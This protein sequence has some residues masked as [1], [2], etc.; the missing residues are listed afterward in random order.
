M[1]RI[2][3]LF[4][5]VC[6]VFSLQAQNAT[7]SGKVFLQGA[8]DASSSL[9]RTYLVQHAAFPLEQPYNRDP[10]NYPGLEAIA[11]MDDSLV[12]WI[13]IELRSGEDFSYQ[14]YQKAVLLKKDGTILDTNMS[15]VLSFPGIK[16]APYYVILRHRNHMPVMTAQPVNLPNLV[17]IDFTD[18]TQT[19]V[20]GGNNIGLIQLSAG[21]FG[22]IAGDLNQDQV[23][24]FS[25][26]GNDR[27]KVI[28]TLVA[29]TGSQAITSTITGYHDE[30]INL[31]T[32][33]KYSGPNNDP[34]RIIQNI[35][36]LTGST[37]INTVHRTHVPGEF[38][39]G[40]DLVDLRDGKTYPT[41]KIGRQC[42]MAKN[43]DHGQWIVDTLGQ[44][45]NQ[46]V[47]KFCYDN[48]PQ[49]C[50]LYGGLY[51]WD[52][53]MAYQLDQ[54]DQGICPVGW[55]LPTDQEWYELESSL[56]PMMPMPDSLG[57]RGTVAGL[58]FISSGFQSLMGGTYDTNATFS[59]LNS[60]ARY[61]TS[62]RNP[63]GQ[64]MYRALQQGN[65]GVLRN[66]TTQPAAM[67]VRCVR[68]LAVKTN[69][70]I[71][72]IDTNTTKLVSDSAMLAQGIYQYNYTAKDSLI[73]N[74]DN[75]IIDTTGEGY[76]R[77]VDSVV[78]LGSAYIMYTRQG[79]L[80]DLFIQGDLSF[81][82]TFQDSTKSS[83]YRRTRIDYLEKGIS[84][85]QSKEAMGFDF[86]GTVLFQDGP[87]TIT[88]TS[89]HL[90]FDPEFEFDLEIKEG[91]VRRL[92]FYTEDALLEDALA[93]NFNAS[94]SYNFPEFEKTLATYRHFFLYGV[95]LV[96]VEMELVATNK[97]NISGNLDVDFGYTNS[98]YLD[99]G[100]IY[101]NGKW[102]HLYD[103]SNQ[104]T[105]HPLE[106]SAQVN[107]SQRAALVPKV[108]VKLYGIV[109]PYFNA[110]AWETLG[111]N[112]ILPAGD[113][114][115][116]LSVGL[117]AYL[118]AEA[119]VFGYEL[120]SYS[121]QLFGKE[122]SIWNAPYN[123]AKVSGD[124]QTATAGQQLPLPIKVR[125]KDNTNH[126]WL[127]VMVHFETNDGSVSNA[128]VMTDADGY[129][130]TLW[131]LG[132]NTGSQS[133][134]ARVVKADGSHILGSPLQFAATATPG[135]ST[136]TCGATLTD[137][138][139]GQ[140][141]PTVQIGTQCWMAKNL[142]I[143]VYKASVNTGST[144]SDVSNNGI[145]EKYC[146]NNDQA[147]C[148]IY[149]GLYDWNEMMNYTTTPG[150]QG[151]CP[152]GWHIPTDAEW[153]TL[154]T[155]LDATVN[156]NTWDWSGTNAGGKM[157]E[158]G[159]THW[160]SPNTGATNS[161]GFTA[162]GAGH[163]LING[164]FLGLRYDAY[165]WSSS[166]Y[167]ST[168]GI[169]RYLYYYYANVFRSSYLKT[170]GFSVRCL[171]N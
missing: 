93:I 53:M 170:D 23:L 132:N 28:T 151:I 147:N 133:L 7:F 33:V 62:T 106:W 21:L 25:G 157:K 113:W 86:D 115:A 166:E 55:H 97:G 49:N 114:D 70:L 48:N 6:I 134:T 11:S 96:V 5:F 50:Q 74:T 83:P 105:I 34:S 104:L 99:L 125:V 142:N 159:T 116:D 67:Y 71:I 124:N 145:I 126:S 76:L 108:S 92:A 29:K 121:K 24:K 136:F 87:V 59:G 10:W 140:Q 101:Q 16:P 163:R 144:H 20:F 90:I 120:A 79:T 3:Q 42:W 57:W 81:P 9:M 39:C 160:L 36:Q 63:G 122:L 60:S 161:S 38:K 138:R 102:K 45:D 58:Q 1:R 128:N 69:P 19:P 35:N 18:T 22:M 162:L 118:G 17:P 109:G 154:T 73:V 111:A 4:L 78:Q 152:T 127:Q 89:G 40:D 135:S 156:C 155:Y 56:D 27:S 32:I 98:R 68:G 139:D 165:F 146:F 94:S 2:S 43:L 77:I 12:D 164:L 91:K 143:G 131:T 95:V 150:T 41:V 46:L 141:Y 148:A 149:G 100:M 26:A 14:E 82:L 37:S 103:V 168:S 65:T 112:L 169:Y 54:Y 158:T 88:L 52:E 13:L 153:C 31:D 85:R 61:W 15:P 129:A 123:I 47:E 75:I 51:Q 130:Q 66:T 167:S 110:E 84:I 44:A 80:E 119:T 72:I 30:D 64:A 117:D 137:T 107:L 171:R 8:Y